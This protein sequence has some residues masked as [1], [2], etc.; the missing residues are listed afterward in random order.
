[1]SSKVPAVQMGRGWILVRHKT[2]V[3]SVWK[4]RFLVLDFETRVLTLYKSENVR[5]FWVSCRNVVSHETYAFYFAI[6]NFNS[7]HSSSNTVC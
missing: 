4:R 6:G 7:R 1:M 3:V 2:G 5:C